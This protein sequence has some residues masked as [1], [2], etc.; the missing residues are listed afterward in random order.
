MAYT[1]QKDQSEKIFLKS[2]LLE[3]LWHIGKPADI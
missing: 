3:S 2:M 1:I